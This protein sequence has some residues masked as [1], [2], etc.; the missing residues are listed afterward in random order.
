MEQNNATTDGELTTEEK[1]ENINERIDELTDL[2][3]TAVEHGFD[4]QANQMMKEQ[5]ECYELLR[6]LDEEECEDEE[7]EDVMSVF[8]EPDEISEGMELTE[9]GETVFLIKSIRGN[10]ATVAIWKDGRRK[11]KQRMDADELQ[12]DYD[13]G[14][15]VVA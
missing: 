11:R 5:N 1:R 13:N 3:N 12:T 6:E 8:D 7:I 2:I 10:D 4:K 9:N 14:N 15:L